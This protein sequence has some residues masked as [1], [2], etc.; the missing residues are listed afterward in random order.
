MTRLDHLKD[1]L[2]NPGMITLYLLAGMIY[3]YA[4]HLGPMGR[5]PL[6]LLAGSFAGLWQWLTGYEIVSMDTVMAWVEQGQ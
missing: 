5:I 1:T 2:I 6:A 4:F 3:L